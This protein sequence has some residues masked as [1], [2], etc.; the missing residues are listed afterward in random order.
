MRTAG[1]QGAAQRRACAK[2]MRLSHVFV[3]RL[4]A[5]PIS[6]WAV[7]TVARHLPPRPITSTPGGGTNENR[8]GAKLSLR[9]ELENVSCVI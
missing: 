8:S 3:E 4:R 7:R 9:F 1:L 5:Q 2:Q 6:Q